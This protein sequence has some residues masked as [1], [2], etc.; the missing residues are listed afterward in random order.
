MARAQGAQTALAGVFESVYGTAPGSGFIALPFNSTTLGS[1]QGLLASPVLGLGRDARKPFRDVI[2]V[3]GEVDVPIDIPTIGIWLKALLGAP[4]TSGT[5]PKTHVFTSGG[6]TLPSLTL[7]KGFAQVPSF[8]MLTG[9]VADEMS[10]SFTRSGLAGA[11]VK[12]IGQGLARA[13]ST[14][15]GTPT[16]YA[17]DQ[18]SQFQGGIKRDASDLADIVSADFTF[19]NGL[20]RAEVIRADGLIDDVD[21]GLATLTGTIVA[22]FAST[23]LLAQATAGSAC[24][25]EFSYTISG[26]KSLTLE[27]PYV[28]LPVG[29]TP[30]NGPG[31]IQVSF[32][33]QASAVSGTP[34]LTATLVN[35]I[36][37]Y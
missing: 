34:M 15:A 25:L 7:E 27:M 11:K 3:D 36:S 24:A 31:G 35:A 26:S 23:T 13:T 14:G 12:L 32:E 37:S 6:L 9:L 30:I 29:R 18:V 5:T 17:L 19:K 10:F 2:N 20:E 22:R 4:S 21:P 33:F 1:E 8:E 16:V 28:Y